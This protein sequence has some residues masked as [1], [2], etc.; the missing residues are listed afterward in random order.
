MDTVLWIVSGAPRGSMSIRNCGLIESAEAGMANASIAVPSTT[1]S[2]VDCHRVSM[3]GRD[4]RR[5]ILVAA[6]AFTAVDVGP[7]PPA[8]VALR[9]W[10]DSWRGIG[11]IV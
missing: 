10:L 9:S 7:M 5:A 2:K 3:E 8:L 6:L 1:A 11:A 4:H